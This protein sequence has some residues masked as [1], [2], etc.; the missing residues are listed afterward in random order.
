MSNQID[1]RYE[2]LDAIERRLAQR[3][4]GWTTG[5]LARELGV[6][7]ST[8]FRDLRFLEGRGTGLIQHGR[9]YLLDHRRSLYTLKMTNDEVQA[10]YLAARLLSRHSDEHNPHV[11]RA[12]EKLADALRTRS[13]LIAHHIDQAAVA[14]RTRRTRR[15]YVEALEALTQGWAEQR[16]VGHQDRQRRVGMAGDQP[17]RVAAKQENPA[18]IG[19]DLGAPLGG[20][21]M[22]FE[23]DGRSR[24]GEPPHL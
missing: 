18:R 23:I 9:R 3:P 17:G 8:I 12:L 21:A 24:C 14:V 11:V 2:R 16:K 20:P 7:A 13:P 10:V 15:A 5:E 6:D 19:V 4:E 22:R 1:S